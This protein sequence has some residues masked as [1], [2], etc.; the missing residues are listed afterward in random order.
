ML[1]A[2]PPASL[3]RTLYVVVPASAALSCRRTP[4]GGPSSRPQLPR[5]LPRRARV[6]R[7]ARAAQRGAR[8]CRAAVLVADAPR[9]TIDIVV[10]DNVD[11]SNGY[12]TPFP[13]NRIVVYAK[14]PVGR[15]RA[16][17]HARLDRPRRRARAR[18]YLPP[19]CHGSGRSRLR[20]CSAGCRTVAVLSGGGHADMEH[21]G[22]GG[23][24]RVG[25]DGAAAACTAATTRWSCALPC[26]QGAS[27]TSTD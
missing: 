14:P 21:R 12:A 25:A 4:R 1:P 9:G 7:A 26:S 18:S 2:Q 15:A 11:F 20:A 19:R 13:S 23:R 16:A 24:R 6:A 27:T 10:S 17:V 8:A 5:H 3:L 22:S